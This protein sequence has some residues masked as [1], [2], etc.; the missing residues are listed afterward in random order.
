MLFRSRRASN[1]KSSRPRPLASWLPTLERLEDKTLPSVVVVKPNIVM[2][3]ATA[4]GNTALTL[5]Y[6]IDGTTKAFNIGLYRAAGA[7]HV[8]GDVA[9]GTVKVTDA[10]DLTAGDH[11][12]TR[13]IGTDVNLPGVGTAEI[14]DDYYILAVANPTGAAPDTNKNDNTAVFSG[15][16][17]AAGGDVFVHGTAGDDTFTI[18]PN[19]VSLSVTLNNSPA[20]VYTTADVGAVRIRTHAGND[21]VDGTTTT[22]SLHIWGGAGNDKITG[23]AGNDFLNGG[24]GDDTITDHV[25]PQIIL[26]PDFPPPGGV[27][28]TGTGNGL[29][30]AGGRT[31]NFSNFDFTAFHQMVWQPVS[32]Q[33]SMNADPNNVVL[34][35][36]ENPTFAPNDP[37]SN[38]NAG[39]GIWT[40]STQFTH[41][42]GNSMVTDTLNTRFRIVVTDGN[43]APVSLLNSTNLGNPGPSAADVVVANDNPNVTQLNNFHVQMFMEANFNNSW[44]AVTDLFSSQNTDPTKEVFV[45]VDGGFYHT[46][47]F[48]DHD[49]ISGGLGTNTI[50]STDKT[51]T[52]VESG[53]MNMVLTNASLVGSVPGAKNTTKVLFTDNLQGVQ[54]ASLTG[55]KG[56]NKLDASA[57]TGTVTLDGGDGNDVLLGGTGQNFLTGGKGTN[58]LDGGTGVTMVIES[59]DNNFVISDTK[60]NGPGIDNMKNVQSAK[61]TGGKSK[62][63][64]DVS[65]FS[66]PITID[67]AGSG[68]DQV[69]AK[70]DADFVLTPTSLTYA[71]RTVTLANISDAALTGGD[72]NNVFT[73]SLWNG[74]D[75][76]SGGKGVNSLNVSGAASFTLSNTK[77]TGSNG[78]S[79]S[80]SQIQKASLTATGAASYTLD[81]HAFTGPVTLTGGS[82]NDILIGGAGDD[83]L[84]GGLGDDLLTGGPGTNAIEGGGGNDTVV[85][86]GNF[87]MTITGSPTAATLTQKVSAKVTYT[88]NLTNVNQASL[89]GGAGNNK[90]DASEFS[91]NVLLV[92]GGGNDTLLGGTGFG[93]LLGGASND[94]L[95]AGNNRSLLVGGTG[96]DTLSAGGATGADDI[97]IGGTLSYYNEAKNTVNVDAFLAIMGEW[98]SGDTYAA[99]VT[100]LGTTGVG[101]GNAIKLDGTTVKNDHS[102]DTLTGG[103][104]AGLDW[105]FAAI[106]GTSLDVLANNN[107]TET[108]TANN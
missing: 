46:P 89:F 77:L 32:V 18:S 58:T 5:S 88:D 41:L 38:L 54:I 79:A 28:F 33:L 74:K 91:G 50:T 62:N 27:T 84:N 100:A 22:N 64:F 51:A 31:F 53:D 15:D 8:T 78:L 40:G 104:G 37:A 108:V 83:V 67:G 44:Q 16:Y 85:E 36:S 66:G 70:K 11:T 13:T 48:I 107:N 21:T 57:F 69:I 99:R 106:T 105:F 24:D 52:L 25:N 80:L 97:L 71:G 90:L 49:V 14:E 65:G 35:Q 101:P 103:T 30:T 92:G 9:L 45:S 93:I 17:H 34:S 59:G 3:S 95:T 75:T 1:R 55:G 86:S 47:R 12:I 81:A 63:T 61:L 60:L 96:K 43:A 39:V 56:N 98:T 20:Q 2:Q 102:V 4:D 68:K 76:I 82:G 87:D 72:S 26:G 29:G 23:G 10:A 19:G 6:H 73:L 94:T 7:T 42:V